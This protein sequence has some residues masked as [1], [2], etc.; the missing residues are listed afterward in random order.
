[1]GGRYAHGADG[2][3]EREWRPRRRCVGG[4]GW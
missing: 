3:L 1:V 2:R 4:K